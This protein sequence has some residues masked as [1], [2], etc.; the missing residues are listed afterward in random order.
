MPD[1]VGVAIKTGFSPRRWLSTV[2]VAAA[3]LIPGAWWLSQ[4]DT[5]PSA[6]PTATSA[7]AEIPR[8]AVLPLIN[9]SGDASKEY[10]AD[11]M[12][13]A[14]I[15]GLAKIGGLQVISRSSVMR[16]KQTDKSLPEIA[17]ELGVGYLIEGSVLP[18]GEQVRISAQ[19]IH[20]GSDTHLWTDNYDERLQDILSVQGRVARA[21]AQQVRVQLSP[22]EEE[23]LAEGRTVDPR[24]YPLY[25]EGRFH[26]NRRTREG[27]ERSL[28]LYKEALRNDPDFAIAHAAQADAYN[29]LGEYGY[30][31]P[32][33]AFPAAKQAALTALRLDDNLGEAYAA[34][35]ETLHYHDWDLA[36]SEAQLKKAI[37]LS[38]GYATAHQWYAEL[39]TNMGRF[40]E[41]LV[42][43]EKA[44]ELDPYS[45]I[46]RYEVAMNYDFSRRYDRALE[47][48]LQDVER[49]PEFWVHR[50]G[51]GMVYSH[52][53]RHAE[54]IDSGRDAVRISGEVPWS[55]CTMGWIL[56][57]A[58]EV[59]EAR[60]I[61]AD[62]DLRAE[63]EFVTP[64]R[65]AMI[66]IGLGDHDRAFALLDEAV[67][68]RDSQA[69]LLNIWA[70]FDPIRD[71]PRFDTLI[72][73]M[74]LETPTPRGV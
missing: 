49:E 39:L 17:D 4:R 34:L 50:L 38:P 74:G 20:A 52:L 33:E 67:E 1:A 19:L 69:V 30:L 3:V 23:R 27:F 60:Q 5:A 31:T 56:A 29:L 40:D 53:Q 43:A 35:G 58:G 11:G 37:E 62:L 54:A 41:S 36:A 7:E 12:T 13:E 66:H 48:A 24:A 45:P 25:L 14:L 51:L 61:A 70:V 47:V 55:L 59:E 10:F 68:I 9:L 16:Y 18:A 72:R 21:V 15:T 2:A 63:Q 22:R 64:F 32:Q 26:W 6:A 71:D 46:V 44:V 42:H 8:I 73:R 65:R 28:E 57:R